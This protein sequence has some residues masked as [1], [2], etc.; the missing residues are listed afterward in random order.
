MFLCV[1]EHTNC[2]VSP[3][4]PLLF[5]SLLLLLEILFR[6]PVI[7][8]CLSTYVS[9]AQSLALLDHLFALCEIIFCSV[10]LSLHLIYPCLRRGAQLELL[11]LQSLW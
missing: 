2:T 1:S 10:G 7:F 3:P 6:C 11:L 4:S 5:W 9:S 8:C